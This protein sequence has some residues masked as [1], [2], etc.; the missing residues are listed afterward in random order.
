MMSGT[1]FDAIDAAVAELALEGEV[2]VSLLTSDALGLPAQDKEACAFAVL[3][4]LTAHGL[5]GTLPGAKYS[6]ILG[7]LTPGVGGLTNLR[8]AVLPPRT[9]RLG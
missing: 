5:P 9:L 1:P 6:R 8:E 3:G 7:S 4:F 2:L